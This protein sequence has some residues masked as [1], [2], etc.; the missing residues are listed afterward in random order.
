MVELTKE[1]KE[2]AMNALPD[3][4]KRARSRFSD[5]EFSLLKNTFA[6]REDLLIIIR[7]VF[8]QIELTK[9]EQA[10]RLT[11]FN[12]EVVSAMRKLFLPEIDGNEPYQQV[13]DLWSK[14]QINIE[15]KI[16]DA[17]I[18]ITAHGTFLEYIRQQLNSFNGTE[19]REF[20]F[21]DLDYTKEAIVKAVNLMARQKIIK[22]VED[23]IGQLMIIA[24]KREES[25]E[26]QLKRIYQNGNR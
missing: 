1:Q 4:I 10:I 18:L 7:K 3:F 2:K 19:K 14:A 13:T 5:K 16:E 26:E 6:D 21:K 24:G 9:E 23:N 17:N 11:T 20:K 12:S 22:H 25:E 15:D 8:L